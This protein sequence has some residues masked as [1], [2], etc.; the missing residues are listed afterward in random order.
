MSQITQGVYAGATADLVENL[1]SE[2]VDETAETLRTLSNDLSEC[3]EI[4]AIRRFAFEIV[5]QA[6]NFDMCLLES[7]AQRLGNFLSAVVAV[8]PTLVL[9]IRAH[10]DVMT[11]I[12]DRRIPDDADPA[13]LVRRLPARPY[14]FDVA[15]V[16]VQDLEVMLV[17]LHNAQTRFI[18]REMQAC[19][20]RVTIVTSTITALQEI[21]RTKPNI[22][23]IS[24]VMPGLSGVDLAIAITAMP[25]TRNTPV[26]L[27]TSLDT[28]DPVLQLIPKNVPIIHKSHRFGDD[29]AAAL[30][31]HFLL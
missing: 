3:S 14:G 15:G 26:A 9:D 5:G 31:Y 12:V 20:Y 17:M 1:R 28:S 25:E 7:V 18:E 2:F 13:A 6:H 8:T 4:E 23:I 19:G 29:L 10:L 22:A 27:I 24:A 30:S 16:D 21:V 11:D